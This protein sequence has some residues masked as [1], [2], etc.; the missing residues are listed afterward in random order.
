M[1]PLYVIDCAVLG[2]SRESS[3]LEVWANHNGVCEVPEAAE[4]ASIETLVQHGTQ[5][6]CSHGQLNVRKLFGVGSFC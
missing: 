3:D 5:H 6:G 1:E 4:L 2:D